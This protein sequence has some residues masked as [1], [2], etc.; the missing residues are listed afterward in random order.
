MDR[1]AYLLS[2][3]IVCLA[4]SILS[5]DSLTLDLCLCLCCT[6]EI[7][8]ELFASHMVEDFLC[9]FQIL[10]SMDVSRLHAPVESHI[11]VVCEFSIIPYSCILCRTRETLIML[12]EFF[13]Q[14]HSFLVLYQIIRYLLSMSLDSEVGLC[15]SNLSLTRIAILSNQIA[16]IPREVIV[17]QF[18]F[19]S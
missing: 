1:R 14:I 4:C 11:S 8:C 2:D 5:L 13:P 3:I 15:L 6:E 18:S 7:R 16:S 12:C 19:C 17:A 9:R 10:P